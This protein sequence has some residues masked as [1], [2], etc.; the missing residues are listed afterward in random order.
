MKSFLSLTAS[1]LILCASFIGCQPQRLDRAERTAYQHTIDSLITASVRAAQSAPAAP[2]QAAK[3][4]DIQQAAAS[5]AA[6]SSPAAASQ[7]PAP[8]AQPAGT[9]ETVTIKGIT[10]QVQT[11]A[12]GGRYIMKEREDGTGTYKSYLPKQ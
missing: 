8:K 5:I 9:G 6:T 3:P 10:Y 4:A 12:K 1:A 7:K 2:Q 11:G